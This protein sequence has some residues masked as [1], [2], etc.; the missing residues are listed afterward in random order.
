MSDYKILS[1]NM[2]TNQNINEWT[3]ILNINNNTRKTIINKPSISISNNQKICTQ[4]FNPKQ[5]DKL[6]WC[7]Y[8]IINSFAFYTQFFLPQVHFLIRYFHNEDEKF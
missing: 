6:F 4:I 3:N 7:L 2:Y 8:V 1:N 5:Y